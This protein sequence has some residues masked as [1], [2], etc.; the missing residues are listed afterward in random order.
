MFAVFGV[1]QLDHCGEHIEEGDE[2]DD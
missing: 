1:G 2:V